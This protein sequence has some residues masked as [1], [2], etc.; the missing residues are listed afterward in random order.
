MNRCRQ[1]FIVT[2]AASAVLLWLSGC[3]PDNTGP[4]TV[5]HRD[6]YLH[7]AT[8]GYINNAG[9]ANAPM[10]Y[11]AN[12][13]E[14][15]FAEG[16]RGVK[17][18]GG[19]YPFSLNGVALHFYGGVDIIGGCNRTT[20]EPIPGQYSRVYA[21]NNPI[22]GLSIR[23]PTLVRG[24]EIMG[25]RPTANRPTSVAAYL[26]GCSSALRFEQCRFVAQSGFD[27]QTSPIEIDPPAIAVPP[28]PGGS[29]SCDSALVVP[30]GRPGY[31]G[32]SG[33]PG[34]AGGLP[35]NAGET[36]R[37]GSG[38]AAG[39]AGLGGLP[40]ENGQDGSDGSNGRDGQNG[41]PLVGLGQ[42]ENNTI[43]PEP[44]QDG[45]SGRAGSGGGGGGGGG[46]ST[47]GTGNGGGGGGTGGLGGH[48]ARGGRGGGHSI[49]VISVNNAAVFRNC[50]FVANRGGR[51]GNGANGVPGA[52]GTPGARGGATCL[53]SV[54]EGGKGGSGGDGGASG[55]GA[56]GNGG[57][58][59]GLIELGT[60]HADLDS[61]C[62]FATISPGI[63]GQGG[64]HG[65]TGIRADDGYPGEVVDHKIILPTHKP[66]TG[67]LHL[68][69]KNLALQDTV[70]AAVR[71]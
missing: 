71:R 16:Y 43:Q 24:L 39:I 62:T 4:Q 31:G 44:G 40:G 29:G 37:H 60:I 58:G 52:A 28:T 68:E 63:P 3:G 65:R 34:G 26:A 7:V 9:T 10:G 17:I 33:G 53:P 30:G 49:G 12:A 64:I 67:V 46:G 48:P 54:G 45:S 61:T 41:I 21:V 2:I 13:I 50:M 6:Q 19:D 35:G 23:V 69:D 36:G 47:T 5:P 18:A 56:G 20:W 42:L 25:T 59:I 8:D 1:F 57:A 11:P 70:S 14:Q 51:G 38:S 55:G 15:A 27:I 22:E 32:L 66:N